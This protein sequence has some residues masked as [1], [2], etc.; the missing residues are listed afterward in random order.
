MKHTHNACQLK[1]LVYWR[2]SRTII[3][4]VWLFDTSTV[5]MKSCCSVQ[6]VFSIEIISKF[7]SRINYNFTLN[8]I[9]MQHTA[10]F[11]IHYRNF[12]S[13]LLST[14]LLCTVQCIL[15]TLNCR[16][17]QWHCE[18]LREV[19][20]ETPMRAHI[21]HEKHAHWANCALH[22]FIRLHDTTAGAMMFMT[23]VDA[24]IR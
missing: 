22:W 7:S 1:Y 20:R 15:N 10:P 19:F 18:K 13:I 3:I 2:V 23:C 16:D 11:Q 17:S 8:S 5:P 6:K 24:R 12:A 9:K 4:L 14:I 21:P